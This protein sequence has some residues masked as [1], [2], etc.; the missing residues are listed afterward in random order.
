MY[1]DSRDDVADV[2][3]YVHADIPTIEFNF[4]LLYYHRH[5]YIAY[6]YRFTVKFVCLWLWWKPKR[7]V[8]G[9]PVSEIGRFLR[10]IR[11]EVFQSSSNGYFGWDP[12]LALSH[13]MMRN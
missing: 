1:N 6:L 2:M 4:I 8:G 7:S 10:I 9:V 3:F 5:R 13:I 12:L 11:S